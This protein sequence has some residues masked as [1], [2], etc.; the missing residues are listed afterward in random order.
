LET[1][2]HLRE[3]ACWTALSGFALGQV[4]IQRY[5][6]MVAALLC[7]MCWA[8]LSRRPVALGL[9]AGAAIAAKIVPVFVA[10][11]CALH[12]LRERRLRELALATTVTVLAGAAICAPAIVAAGPFSLWS[13]LQY[14][15]DRPLELESTA[16]SVLGLG[17][18]LDPSSTAVTY[19]YG[20]YN[21]V[22]RFTDVGLLM[23]VLACVAAIG[24][25]YVV[26][27]QTLAPQHRPSDRASGL[28]VVTVGMLAI[29]IA[30]WKV[31]S[32]QYLWWL[33]PLG[34]LVGL[35]QDDWR[36]LTLIVAA[37]MLA[38]IVFP[39]G[40]GAAQSLRAWP[41][42]LILGRNLILVIWAG[43]IVG[44]HRAR[45]TAFVTPRK[46]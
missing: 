22:G 8:T 35:A 3:L 5:D 7:V 18:S 32:L 36:G 4:T 16:A 33:M 26:A 46:S 39:L 34:V 38:Q 25:L 11:L 41:Y 30:C 27:W 21:L 24:S 45:S 10:I 40:W 44:R 29:V 37:L 14:H 17:H 20:S 31:A 28:L 6:A 1:T 42:A 15:R 19:A 13:V 12:L 43:R 2:V 9:S 23:S